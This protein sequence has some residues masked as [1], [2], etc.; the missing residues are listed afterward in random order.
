MKAGIEFHLDTRV[1]EQK[2]YRTEKNLVMTASQA[3]NDTAY[4][5]QADTKHEISRTMHVR[6][7]AFTFG[8]VKV[9]K[10]L[11][12]KT[13]L[14]ASVGIFPKKR[15]FLTSYIEGGER[16]TTTKKKSSKRGALI[17]RTGSPARPTIGDVSWLLSDLQLKRYQVNPESKQAVSSREARRK[18]G[19]KPSPYY[20]PSSVFWRSEQGREFLIPGVGVFER[21]G[22]G[23]SDLDLLWSVQRHPVQLHQL[24]PFFEISRQDWQK[25]FHRNFLERIAKGWNRKWE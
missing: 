23:R 10:S 17:P 12:F 18:A 5:I 20:A 24:L 3:L 15:S 16:P 8:Q 6:N 19:R 25:T 22:P 14:E 4:Q 7:E 2:L 13:G 11:V 21:T 9:K 1:L